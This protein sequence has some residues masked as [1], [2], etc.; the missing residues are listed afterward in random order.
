[1]RSNHWVEVV[2]ATELVR[3]WTKRASDP[4]RSERMGLRL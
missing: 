2:K 1:V 3:A 4:M